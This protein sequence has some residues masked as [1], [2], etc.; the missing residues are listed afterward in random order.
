MEQEQEKALDTKHSTAS[1]AARVAK[2]SHVRKLIIGH[3]SARYKDLSGLLDEAKKVF[4]ETFL[5]KE[6]DTFEMT[7][8]I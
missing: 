8:G 3:F 4:P 5:A 6:G 2:L 7:D 1:G